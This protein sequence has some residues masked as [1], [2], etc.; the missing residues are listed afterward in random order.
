MSLLPSFYGPR[1]GT[2]GQLTAGRRS[3]LPGCL[4]HHTVHSPGSFITIDSF[5]VTDARGGRTADN[6]EAGGHCKQRA[7]APRRSHAPARASFY[8]AL[9][10]CSRTSTCA[11]FIAR[12]YAFCSNTLIRLLRSAQY[13]ISL[14]A[15]FL[16]VL[17]HCACHHYPPH[18]RSSR[19]CCCLLDRCE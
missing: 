15:S 9:A 16:D 14:R 6:R 13:T 12:G 7:S 8:Q 2:T 19:C 5:N 1:S 4:Y 11:L 17:P 18:A 3:C 10:F